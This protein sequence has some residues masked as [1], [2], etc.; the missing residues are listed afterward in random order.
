MKRQNMTKRTNG[1]KTGDIM[2]SKYDFT[3]AKR[4]NH[5]QRYRR[6]HEVHIERADGSVTVQR[7]SLE[8]GAVLLEPDV[9]A[10]FKDSKAVNRALRCLIP[11]VR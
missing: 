2:K 9:R 10:V 1:R 7:F 4:T 11:L 3:K 5:A 8:D 6:G